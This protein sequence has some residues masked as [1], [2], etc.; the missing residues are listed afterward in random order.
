MLVVIV[1]PIVHAH[2]ILIL[3]RA[4][5]IEGVS[6]SKRIDVMFAVYSHFFYNYIVYK[7][8]KLNTMHG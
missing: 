8:L 5:C 6:Q 2:K 7:D 1:K 4:P 3:G